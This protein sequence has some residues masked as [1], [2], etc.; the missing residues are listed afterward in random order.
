MER[1]RVQAG[2]R[3]VRGGG[4]GGGDGGTVIENPRS[5]RSLACFSCSPVPWEARDNDMSCACASAISSRFRRSYYIPPERPSHVVH[6][7]AR[8]HARS[9]V[10]SNARVRRSARS[11]VW[12]SVAYIYIYIDRAADPP[13]PKREW[14]TPP[15]VP[16]PPPPPVIAIHDRAH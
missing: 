7:R 11:C 1:V 10:L 6:A 9:V 14:L 3:S 2:R 16:P 5:A 12:T 13:T 8:T 15:V 4:G